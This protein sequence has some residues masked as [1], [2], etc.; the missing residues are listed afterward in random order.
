MG[1][2]GHSHKKHGGT[3]TTHNTRDCCR[4][5]RNR[6]EKSNFCA[7]KKDERKGNPVNQNFVQLTKNIKKLEKVLKKSGQ[8]YEKVELQSWSWQIKIFRKL[9][10]LEFMIEHASQSWQ[11]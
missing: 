4:F 1:M 6:K 9:T 11:S 2:M 3:Y 7:A 8:S 10:E 5:D